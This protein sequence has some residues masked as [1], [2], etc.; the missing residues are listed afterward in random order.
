MTRSG[1]RRR[2]TSGQTAGPT[3]VSA[4]EAARGFGRLVDRVREER[5]EY[6]VE[7]GGVAVA[8]IGPASRR[9]CTL[10]DLVTVLRSRPPLDESY[11]REVEAVSRAANRPV[12]PRT[13]WERSS[14]RVS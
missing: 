9:R 11:L 2:D 5:A 8:R 7:R 6:V 14:T 13:P 4:T 1:G 3:V 10:R 12:I